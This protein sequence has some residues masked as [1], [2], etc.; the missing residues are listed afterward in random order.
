[1]K[2]TRRRLLQAAAF[3]PAVAAAATTESIRNFAVLVVREPGREA[4]H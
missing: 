3:S 4:C 1:M 2:P